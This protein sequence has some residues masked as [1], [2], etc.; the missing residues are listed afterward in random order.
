MGCF[1]VPYHPCVT[2]SLFTS[3]IT[4]CA[5]RRTWGSQEKSPFPS[6]HD[7][8]DLPPQAPSPGISLH[9]TPEPPY[10]QMQGPPWSQAA[11]LQSRHSRDVVSTSFLRTRLPLAPVPG[12]DVAQRSREPWAV[13]AGAG[14]MGG[15]LFHPELPETVR[16][17]FIIDLI[18]I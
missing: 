9:P 2:G 14:P 16:W 7:G 18:H 1:S 17:S 5:P 15:S 10:T 8:R 3:P 13:T 4:P 12:A 11:S 6:V